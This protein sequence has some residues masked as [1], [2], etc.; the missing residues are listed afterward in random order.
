MESGIF[1]E[2]EPQRIYVRFGGKIKT[3]VFTSNKIRH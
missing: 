1:Q 3:V 2:T